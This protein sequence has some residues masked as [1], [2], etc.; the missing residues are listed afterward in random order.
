MNSTVT[1][2]QVECCT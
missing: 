2:I 1:Y